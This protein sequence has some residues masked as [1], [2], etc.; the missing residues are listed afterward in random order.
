[1]KPDASSG[2]QA[3]PTTLV[4]RSSRVQS[5]RH[6]LAIYA[7]LARNSL[8]REMGFKVNFM[9]WIVVELLWFALQLTFMM[10]V[11][12][13]TESIGD[14]TKWEVVLLVGASHFIQQVFQAFFLTNV[15]QL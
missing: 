8:V 7:M 14:W 4:S 6:Y 5:L 12:A 1:M 9:L 2:S 3:P 15:T 11:Y 13:H 10:V